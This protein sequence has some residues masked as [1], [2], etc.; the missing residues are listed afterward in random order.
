MHIHMLTQVFPPDSAA[1]GQY[2]EEAAMEAAEEGHKVT[3]WTADRDYDDPSIRYDNRSRHPRIRIR[4]LP[5]SSF[6]K[7][8][9]FHRLLGQASFLGQCFIRL[10]FARKVDRLVVTTIPATTGV[11]L[12]ILCFFRSFPIIYWVM[13]INPDQAVALGLARPNGPGRRLLDAVNR[14]LLRK[15]HRVIALDSYMANRLRQ[16]LPNPGEWEKKLRIIPPWPLR[17]SSTIAPDL[18][19][20][21]AFRA[22]HGLA[23]DSFL[24]MYA[25]NHSL[26]HP[27]DGILRAIAAQPDWGETCFAFIGGGRGKMAVDQLLAERSGKNLLSL[28][29]QPLS[30][31]PGVLSAADVHLVALGSA[32]VGIVHPCKI[33]TAMAVGKPILLYGPA[34]SP[35]G[36]MI[37]THQ[38]GW[39]IEPE[40][41]AGE[42][43][44]TLLAIRQTGSTELAAMGQRSRHVIREHYH[45][46]TLRREFLENLDLN[47]SGTMEL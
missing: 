5:F 31:V 3:V 30:E 36:E 19:Q 28:P 14:R 43:G 7:K 44:D 37:N 26:V 1:V 18:S 16:K 38:L 32:M 8:T 33:Y 25:G 41:T 45:P 29:Y 11:M 47:S 42:I 13:D 6:G 24:F 12:A 22:E 15:A 23:P 34:R 35:L 2:F 40:A 27:L 20:S 39:I 17:G 10:L 9:I 21:K 4:R 46:E